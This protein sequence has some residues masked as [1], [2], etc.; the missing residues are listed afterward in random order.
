MKVKNE[1]RCGGMQFFSVMN[2]LI[3][4]QSTGPKAGRYPISI[5]GK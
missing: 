2:A 1:K 3:R 4:T 5:G